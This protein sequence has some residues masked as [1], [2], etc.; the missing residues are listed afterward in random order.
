M[1]GQC[2][3][4][5]CVGWSVCEGGQCVWEG[6]CVCGVSV[7]VCV[8]VLLLVAHPD[9]ARAE[10][11]AP[12]V[13]ARL[14]RAVD[15]LQLPHGPFFRVCVCVVFVARGQFWFVLVAD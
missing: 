8:C 5:Q 9:A 11:H 3:G 10:H 6:V 7:C 15:R 4:G 14:E 12:L 13:P 1:G 2:V